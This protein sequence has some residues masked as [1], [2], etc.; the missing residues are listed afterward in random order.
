MS[1]HMITQ[2][3][4]M[5]QNRHRLIAEYQQFKAETKIPVR[6]KDWIS[7]EWEREKNKHID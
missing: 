4:W 5:Y 2:K 6:W 3:E 7:D 1:T